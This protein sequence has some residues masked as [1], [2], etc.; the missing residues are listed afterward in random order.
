MTHFSENEGFV[1]CGRGRL[2]FAPD[3]ECRALGDAPA[4][5]Q[6]GQMV[7]GRS[8]VVDR[9]SDA[10]RDFGWD[11][12]GVTEE[13][14]ETLRVIR[15][16]VGDEFV[17]LGPTKPAKLNIELLDVIVGPFDFVVDTPEVG[18]HRSTRYAATEDCAS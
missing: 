12:L 17:W 7:K 10:E 15:I 18:S 9:I 2:R 13:L 16:G 5:S 4:D 1:L 11:G 14:I 6:T 8:E 3:W